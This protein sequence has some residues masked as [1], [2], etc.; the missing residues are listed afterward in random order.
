MLIADV[1]A[2]VVVVVVVESDAVS[3]SFSVSLRGNR[4][5]ASRYYRNAIL[6][7]TLNKVDDE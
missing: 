2:V 1:V 7:T 4:R 6:R 3:R 5:N